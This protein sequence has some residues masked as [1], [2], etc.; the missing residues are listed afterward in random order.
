MTAVR[1]NGGIR[2]T[3]STHD[4]VYSFA[5]LPTGAWALTASRAGYPDSAMG[6]IKVDPGQ[7]GAPRHGDECLCGPGNK[8]SRGTHARIECAHIQCARIERE[9]AARCSAAVGSGTGAGSSDALGRYWIR[10]LDEWH[11]ARES[12]DLRH[13]VFHTPEIRFDM[14][15]L[16]SLNHPQD[17]TIVGSTEEFRSGEFQIEQVSLGGDFH[18]ENVRARFLSMFGMFATTT[19]RNDASSSVGQWDLDDA[20]RYFSEANAGYHFDVNHGLNVDLGVFVSYIGLFS[21]YNY[22]NW[23]YQPVVCFVEYAVVF[24]WSA[25]A[26]VADPKSE[27]RTVVNQWLAVVCKVQPKTRFRRPRCCGC[28]TI[29]SNSSSTPIP[30]DKII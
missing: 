17:H 14:N 12:G 30:L 21:Y 5:D 4:G 15:Y 2:A 3:I 28:R 18:Y 23:T 8:R 22:D 25:R 7:S 24:Q 19:P 13:E 27:N 16:Q 9:C 29:R 6:T 10:G 11:I 26:M 20:Y 1:E